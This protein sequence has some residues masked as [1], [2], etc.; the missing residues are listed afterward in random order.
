MRGGG[1]PGR[2]LI[3][4]LAPP[5]AGPAAPSRPAVQIPSDCHSLHND[6]KHSSVAHFQ[7]KEKG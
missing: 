3:S 4:S 1:G 6:A 2:N 7:G 5:P